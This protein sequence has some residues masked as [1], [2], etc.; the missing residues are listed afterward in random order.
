M[1]KPNYKKRYREACHMTKQPHP[2]LQLLPL[3]TT[4]TTMRTCKWLWNKALEMYNTATLV[5]LYLPIIQHTTLKQERGLVKGQL[6]MIVLK[7]R[8]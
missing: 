5:T 6:P 1:R 8:Q 2:P 4:V 7:Q 3:L